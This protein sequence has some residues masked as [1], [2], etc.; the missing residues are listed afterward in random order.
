MA[1]SNPQFF[2]FYETF[3]WL[4]IRLERLDLNKEKGSVAFSNK[5]YSLVNWRMDVIAAVINSFEAGAE[6]Q[7]DFTR[8]VLIEFQD[9]GVSRIFAQWTQ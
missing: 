9:C 1:S 8:L 6:G 5:C 3:H 7:S 2:S 4:A